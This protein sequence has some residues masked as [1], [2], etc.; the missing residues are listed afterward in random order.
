M[1]AFARGQ[2]FGLAALAERGQTF[3]QTED[4][5][6]TA[7]QEEVTELDRWY[8]RAPEAFD[9]MPL[10]SSPEQVAM[11]ALMAQTILCASWSDRPMLAALLVVRAVSELRRW[12]RLVPTSPYMIGA[13][14]EVSSATTGA[15]RRAA[16]WV[17]PAARAA[18]RTAS[19]K[20]AECLCYRG[21]YATY[22]GPAERSSSLYEKAIA[23]G[24]KSGSL[25]G[26]SWGLLSELIYCRAWR[27]LPLEQVEAQRRAR[28]PLVQRAGDA[29]GK[30]GFELYACWCDLLMDPGGA[31]RLLSSEPLSRSSHTFLAEQDSFWAEMARTLEAHLFLVAGAHR[32]ALPRAREA[33]TFRPAIYGCP[34]VTDVPL[35]LA[36]AAAKCWDETTDAQE[37]AS[38][39]DHLDDGLARL[40]F[41]A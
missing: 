31:K 24:L 30:R 10:S 14:A 39:R 1:G 37:Q 8:E 33:E 15:Y 38:L 29:F 40:R 28:F 6:L 2:Q 3:P 11:D 21:L 26:A 23:V 36:L 16:R 19:P 17:E 20:L 4:A 34:S 22:S 35:W 18:E 25:Q 32:R 12:G 27:G 41:F 13:L 9:G 7:Y 5:C